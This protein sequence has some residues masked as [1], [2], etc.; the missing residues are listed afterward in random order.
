VIHV[1]LS[2]EMIPVKRCQEFDV[3]RYA[4]AYA[5][6]A[7]A[8]SFRNNG[9]IGGDGFMFKQKE[10]GQPGE[11]APAREYCDGRSGSNRLA[12]VKGG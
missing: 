4:S 7:H 10:R 2:S 3:E 12:L 11:K 9:E 5:P 1:K 6:N 8:L